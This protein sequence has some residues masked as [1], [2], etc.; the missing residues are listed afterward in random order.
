MACR[1]QHYMRERAHF[2]KR[3]LLMPSCHASATDTIRKG[4]NMHKCPRGR[5]Q[6]PCP[7]IPAPSRGQLFI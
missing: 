4:V 2:F 5:W 7:H 1:A 6:G 3:C